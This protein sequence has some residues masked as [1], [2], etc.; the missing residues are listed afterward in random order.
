[1]WRLARRQ[2]GVVTRAQLHEHGYGD[3]AIYHRVERGRLHRV[4]R[5]VFA[6]GSPNLS[7]RGRFSA[8]VLAAGAGALLSHGS[9]AQLWGIRA[10]GAGRIEVSISHRASGRVRGVTLHRRRCLNERDRRARH[11]IPVTSPIRTLTDLASSLSASQLEAAVNEADKLDLADPERLRE[12]LGEMT[13][14]PG[15]AALRTLLDRRTFVLTDSELERFFLPLVRR[16]GLPRPETGLTLNGFEVDFFWPDLGLVIETDGLRY[17]RTPA[18]QARDRLRDQAHTA[19]GL[20]PL[21]FTH[22]QI[23]FETEYVIET[24]EFVVERLSDR[25]MR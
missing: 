23:R 19:A 3:S 18:Q 11:G 12:A 20:T 10:A 6:V 4:H 5:G 17:H 2:H 15:V 16:V 7:Q 22:T 9:A 8:A 24:V 1:V 21:R 14:Q 25:R 13:G